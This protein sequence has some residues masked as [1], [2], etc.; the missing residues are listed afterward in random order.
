MS[1]CC[2]LLFYSFNPGR[3]QAHAMLWISQWGWTGFDR[4]KHLMI[5]KRAD[6]SIIAPKIKI[7]TSN[8]SYHRIR[9]PV[10]IQHPKKNHSLGWNHTMEVSWMVWWGWDYPFLSI[11]IHSYNHDIPDCSWYN[12]ILPMCISHQYPSIILDTIIEITNFQ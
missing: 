3:E 8:E 11:L 9:S 1:F 5:E 12:T 4:P 6:S 7:S 10:H 2:R